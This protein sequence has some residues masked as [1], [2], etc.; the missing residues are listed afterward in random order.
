MDKSRLIAVFATL[1]CAGF[2]PCAGDVRGVSGEACK[3]LCSKLEQC[4]PTF[5]DA[6]L[7]VEDC[8]YECGNSSLSPYAGCWA[9][10]DQSSCDEWNAC[11]RKCAGSTGGVRQA[12]AA[13]YRQCYVV[14]GVRPE[15]LDL[16]IQTDCASSPDA[17]DCKLQADSQYDACLGRTDCQLIPYRECQ[18]ALAR[19]YAKCEGK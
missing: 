14:F 3:A 18:S 19:A 8:L 11:R 7:Q 4:E 2:E 16:T 15:D 9:G 13:V 6:F 1:M 12:C 17:D 5:F 10:C